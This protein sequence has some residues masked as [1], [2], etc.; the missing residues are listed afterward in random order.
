MLKNF[1]IFLHMQN[2][3]ICLAAAEAAGA[4]G[5]PGNGIPPFDTSNGG[6]A[7]GT[8]CAEGLCL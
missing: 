6:P 1:Y 7:D 8:D 3:C 5:E 2:G 4:R